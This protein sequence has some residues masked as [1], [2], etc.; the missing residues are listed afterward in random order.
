MDFTEKLTEQYAKKIY[1]FAY[2]KTGNTHDAEDLSQSILL[3]L[4]KIDFE[5][6]D[7]TGSIGVVTINLPRIGYLTKGNKEAFYARLDEMLN[8]AKESLEIKREWLQT[9]V[10]DNN[11]IPAYMEY[12]GTIN[13][14]FNTIGIVGMNDL[15]P[16]D[17][18]N[19]VV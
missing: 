3:T 6:K 14:H 10:L 18:H 4:C 12:V 7:T 16:F 9:N 15:C 17:M 1:G 2:S 19:Y 11:L 5:G 8:I 13:N